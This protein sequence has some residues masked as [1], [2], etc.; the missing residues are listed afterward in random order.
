MAGEKKRGSLNKGTQHP[1]RWSTLIAIGLS[2]VVMLYVFFVFQYTSAQRAPV[3]VS[4]S[5]YIPKTATANEIHAANYNSVEAELTRLR[6]QLFLERQELHQQRLLLQAER[7]EHELQ[8]VKHKQQTLRFQVCNGFGNQRLAIMYAA[9]LARGTNRALVLPQLI[10]EGTQRSFA[11][12]R[13]SDDSLIDF[14]KVYDV[15]TFVR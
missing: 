6:E 4:T 7:K 15:D 1:W 8:L 3:P 10:S 14:S 2:A 9:I 5:P 13:G 12:N 11:E